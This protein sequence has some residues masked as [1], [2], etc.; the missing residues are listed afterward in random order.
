MT[1]FL[2]NEFY[3]FLFVTSATYFLCVVLLFIF[4]FIRAV[5]YDVKTT[6]SFSVIEKILLL[7]SVGIII[8]Y[9]V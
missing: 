6:M 4:R 7:A 2:I 9:L 3:Q 1:E 5:V 8:T